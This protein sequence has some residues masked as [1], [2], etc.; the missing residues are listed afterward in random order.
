MLSSK[1]LVKI[2][3][4][5]R[6]IGL[7]RLIGSLLIG[8]RYEERFGPAF[9]ACIR[10]GDTVWDVGANVGLYTSVFVDTTGQSGRVVAFE[11]S[12]ACFDELRRRFF[13][14]AH[15]TLK[16]MALG[17]ADGTIAMAVDADPLAAT[18]HIVFGNTSGARFV[19]VEIRAASSWVKEAPDLFPN[20]VKIDVE[21]H[22]C[23]VLDGFGPLL[24]DKRLH[25][26]GI[27][28]HF[29]L[30]DARGESA[31]P[32]QMEQTLERNGFAV[33]WTDPSHLLAT[34]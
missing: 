18:H 8:S 5:T 11:P 2:R 20:A 4:I 1:F 19:T 10:T 12:I 34:R 3:S 27:E 21:G 25:S 26:I 31:G 6:K 30:L 16:N 24:A 15:V 13:D 22:E 33:R 14:S 28:V 23:A 29:G 17:D 32:R 9:K 7:N